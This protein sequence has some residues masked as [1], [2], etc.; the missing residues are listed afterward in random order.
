MVIQTIAALTLANARFTEQTPPKLDQQ[1]SGPEAAANRGDP[2][3]AILPYTCI[4]PENEAKFRSP[5]LA[6]AM[7]IHLGA[8]LGKTTEQ[9]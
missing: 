2:E 4:R 1:T 3:R 5:D 6:V 7:G 8:G 9:P